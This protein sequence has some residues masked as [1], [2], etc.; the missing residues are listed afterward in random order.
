MFDELVTAASTA[1]RSGAVAGWARV[2]S[3]ACA[4]RLAA[5]VAVLD[6]L[7]VADG[8]ADREQWYL[9]NWGAACAAIGAAQQITSAAASRQLLVA[10]ALRDRL[11]RVGAVFV[12]GGLTYALASTIVWRTAAIQDP[13]A[14]GAVDAELAEALSEWPAMRWATAW[15]DWRVCAD[16]PTAPPRGPQPRGRGLVRGRRWST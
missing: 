15:T 1:S 13:A 3:A 5:M 6:A 8:S 10:T 7:Y 9:D 4:R 12:A 11:P 2:E 16:N 14:L